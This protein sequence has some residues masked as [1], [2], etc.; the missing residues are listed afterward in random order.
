MRVGRPQKI[1]WHFYEIGRLYLE[2]PND[3]SPQCGAA[4]IQALTGISRTQAEKLGDDGHY[5]TESMLNFLKDFGFSLVEITRGNMTDVYDTP[6]IKISENHVILA[7]L[8]ITKT[9]DSWAV[10]YGEKEFHSGSLSPLDPLDMFNSPINQAWV[11]WHPNW[12]KLR[13]RS[14]LKKAIWASTKRKK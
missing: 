8:R 7:D 10:I 2:E 12:D 4:A 3:C 11:L 6:S 13:E 1:P 9:D 5:S 14:F